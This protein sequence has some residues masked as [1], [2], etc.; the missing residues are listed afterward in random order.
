MG[1]VVGLVI[2]GFNFVLEVVIIKIRSDEVVIM[3]C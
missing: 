3:M 1:V 2:K